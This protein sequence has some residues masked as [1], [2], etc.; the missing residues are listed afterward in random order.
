MLT[1][2]AQQASQRRASTSLAAVIERVRADRKLAPS[3]LA[4]TST[5]GSGGTLGSF[6][7]TNSQQGSLGFD[8]PGSQSIEG[9]RAG[10]ELPGLLPCL[11][12]CRQDFSC[13]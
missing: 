2:A 11:G 1:D 9:V 10:V 4:A 13:H 7:I 3:T 8:D 5:L 12:Q 6:D